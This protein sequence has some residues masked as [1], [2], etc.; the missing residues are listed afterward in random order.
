MITEDQSDVIAFL[1]SPTTH[2]G[3]QVERI[4]TY[5]SSR[6]LGDSSG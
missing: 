1:S 6:Q 4:D 3:N 2:G 5:T